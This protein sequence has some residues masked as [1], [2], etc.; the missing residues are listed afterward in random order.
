MVFVPNPPLATPI[1][2][3]PDIVPFK[4]GLVIVGLEARTK[5]PL[6][7]V[8]KADGL[9]VDPLKLPKTVPFA[10]KGKLLKVI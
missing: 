10:I 5:L 1:I 6:P 7:D 8:F 9:A 3:D 4:T 2:V